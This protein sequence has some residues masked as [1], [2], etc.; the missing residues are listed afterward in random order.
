M[1]PRG[2]AKL[3]SPKREEILVHNHVIL[4]I[5]HVH[6]EC[7]NYFYFSFKTTYHA[8]LMDTGIVE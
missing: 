1:A 2:Y 7:V 6:E 4:Y 5:E 3:C 8:L